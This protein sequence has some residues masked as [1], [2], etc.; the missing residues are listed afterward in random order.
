MRESETLPRIDVH[1]SDAPDLHSF[2]ETGKEEIN[3]LLWKHLPGSV[4]LGDAEELACRIYDLI[5]DQ[6][7]RR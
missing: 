3:L 4:S 2:L 6:W 7:K 5:E 1:S